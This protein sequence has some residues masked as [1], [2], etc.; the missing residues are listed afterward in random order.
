MKNEKK[1]KAESEKGKKLSTI[2]SVT[3][4]DELIREKYKEVFNIWDT[5]KS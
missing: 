2:L 3:K 1:Y 5:I 4:V